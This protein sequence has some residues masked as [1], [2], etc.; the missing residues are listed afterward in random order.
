MTQLDCRATECRYNQNKMCCRAGITVEGTTAKMSDET[1][2][3][4]YE[5]GKDGCGCNKAGEPDGVTQVSCDAKNCDYNVSG[6]C[7]A[8]SIDIA[9]SAG[10]GQTKC[11]SFIMK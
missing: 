5:V 10:A 11:A 6:K 4:N 1:Y 7:D 2:C 9:N 3:G 8:G